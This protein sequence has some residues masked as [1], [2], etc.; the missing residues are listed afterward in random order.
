MCSRRP[1]L[2]GSRHIPG[3][4]VAVRIRDAA[5][6]GMLTLAKA[7]QCQAAAYAAQIRADT[8]MTAKAAAFRPAAQV[9]P[10]DARRRGSRMTGPRR[11][12]AYPG[13]QRR[14]RRASDVRARLLHDDGNPW[15]LLQYW[16]IVVKL[17]LARAVI[18]TFLWAATTISVGKPEIKWRQHSAVHQREPAGVIGQ[19]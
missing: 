6:V 19:H 15:Q 17:A 1:S 11:C 4:Q 18:V 2:R 5:T 14:D 10:R 8:V 12:D 16:W 13:D 7:D 3:Q 9:R